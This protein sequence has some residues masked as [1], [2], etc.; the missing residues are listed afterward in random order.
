MENLALCHSTIKDKNK[1]QILD[2]ETKQCYDGHRCNDMA[3]PKSADY[4]TAFDTKSYLAMYNGVFNVNSDETGLLEFRMK[5]LH[6]FWSNIK[7]SSAT[8]VSSF[9]CLEYGGGPCIANLV[10]ASPKVGR[11]VF[12]EYTEDNREAVKSWIAGSTEAYDW[13]PLVRYVVCELEGD[14]TQEAIPNRERDMKQKIKSIVP[15]DV[16]KNPIVGLD[17]FDI[18]KPF[19][20]VSTS[21]CV[22]V[23]AASEG[24]YKSTVAK[25]CKLLKP[26]GYLLMFGILEETY[27][28]VGDAKF[29]HFPVSRSMVEEAM[30]EAG[31][32]EIKMELF[33]IGHLKLE[34]ATDAKAFF[35]ASGRMSDKD[36]EQ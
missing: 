1:A 9:R 6:K 29:Y 4:R 34:D 24:H 12:A 16:T 17:C 11:I 14:S 2:A 15:C 20:V 26:N 13:S 7:L 36:K 25:L 35:H 10:S 33:E 21:L 19:D 31:I 30:K 32:E 23:C 27:Y 8:D 22:E 5:P 28:V 3:E 18:G